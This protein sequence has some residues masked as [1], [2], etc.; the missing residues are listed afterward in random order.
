MTNKILTT[1]FILFCTL[2]MAVMLFDN[3]TVTAQTTAT[4][5]TG[6]SSSSSRGPVQIAGGS[7]TVITTAFNQVYTATEL[8]A[9]GI[10][11]GSTITELQWDIN[12]TNI[13]Q[14]AGDASFKIYIRNSSATSATADTWGNTISG[15]TLVLDRT[16]NTTDNFPGAEGY[17]A[18]PLTTPF[19]YTGD[20][21]EIAVLWDMSGV[22][23]DPAGGVQV[24]DNADGNNGAIKW[25]Y[26]TTTGNLVS[27]KTS[28]STISSG[29]SLTLANEERANMQL[30]YT[31]PTSTSCS[32]TSDPLGEGTS[33]SATRGPFQR[34]SSSSGSVH[35]RAN[36]VYTQAELVTNLGISSGSTISQINW[37]LGSTNTITATGDAT[38]NIY[39]KNSSVTEATFNTWTNIID[40]AT[41]VGTYTFNTSNNFSGIEGFMDFPLSTDFVYT[42]GT[43]EVAVEWDC[44]GLTSTTGDANEL[45]SGNG[46]LNWHWEET[47]HTSLVYRAGSSSAPSDLTGGDLKAERVNT[48]FVYSCDVSDP[49]CDSDALGAGTSSSATRGP[50]QRSSSSSGS[51]HSRANMVY[52]QAEILNTLGISNG[53][54]ISQ[55][56]WDLG[57]TNIITATGDATLNIY[58]KNSTVSEAT[59]DT[60][61]NI[62]DGATLVGTYT[63]NTSNNFPGAKGFMDFP[64][65]TDFVYTGGT[66]EVAVEWDCSGLT[67]TT[68]DAN[69]LFSGNGSLNWFW[70]ETEHTSLIYRTGSS[71]APSDLTG[72][73]LKAERVNTQFVYS[74]GD[75]S[76]FDCNGTSLVA[77]T[78]EDTYTL[79]TSVLAP[80]ADPIETPDCGHTEFD[81]H[82]TQ[83]YDADLEKDVFV[84]H[85]HVDEDDDRCINFDRQ[86]NE[87]K[88]YSESPD[89][90]LGTLGE[91]VQYKWKFK[92]DAGFQSSA[93]FTHIHQLKSVG[94]SNNEDDM[95]QITFTTRKGVDGNPDQ[96]E[97]RYAEDLTQ[98]TWAQTDLTP[99]KG[100]WVEAVE[101]VTYGDYGNG[102]YSLEIKKVSDGSVLFTHTENNTRMWKT[103]ATFIRPKWGIYRSLEQEADLRDEEVLFAD[104]CIEE[105]STVSACDAPPTGLNAT[106]I[107]GTSADLS[108]GAVVGASTYTWK[109]VAAGDGSGGTAIDS[110][111][112]SNTTVST[113]V[114]S[115]STSYDLH[116]E[117]DCSSDGTTGYSTAYNF[118]TASTKITT[119]AIGTGTSS[120]SSRG[121]IHQ[122]GTGASTRYSRYFHVFTQEELFAAGL[123][124]HGSITDLQW[125]LNS[126]DIITGAGDAPFKIYIKNSSATQATEDTWTNL[127]DG[128]T[129]VLDKTFNEANNFPG[130][131]GWMPFT[132]DT[133]FFYTGGSL[134]V[135]VEWDW[136]SVAFTNDGAIKWYYSTFEED[137]MVRALGSTGHSTNLTKSSTSKQR[138]NM[139]ICYEPPSCAAP[140]GLS[141]TNRTINSADLGWDEVDGA[142]SYTWKV[143]EAG[144]GVDATAV[145]TGTTASTSAS[146]ADLSCGT[147]YDLYVQADC[148][149]GDESAFSLPYS[150]ATLPSAAENTITI[151]TGTSSSSSRGPIQQGGG[152]SSTRYSRF[153]QV[154]T[155]AELLDAGLTPNSLITEL[156]WDLNSTDII[157]GSGD[158]PFKV[159]I[160]NSM[161]TEATPIAWE[162]LI[163]GLTPVVDKVF[164]TT[165]NFPGVKGWMPFSF[166]EPFMYTGGALEIAVEWDYGSISEPAFTGSD[167]SNP[168]GGS[169]KWRYSTF[170]HD[171][172]VRSLGSG[173]Y[174]TSNLSYSTSSTLPTERANIQIISIPVS[175]TSIVGDLE[176]CASDSY[177]TL[178]AGTG[179]EYM[180]SNSAVS[181]TIEA[182]EGTYAVTVTDADGCTATGSASVTENANPMPSVSGD[183]GHCNGESTT[184][185]AGTW[186]SYFWSNNA[187]TQTITATVGDYTVTVTNSNDCTGIGEVS[188]TEYAAPIPTI[189]GQ[190]T[191]CIG[192]N[193]ILNAGDW[194]S[195]LWSNNAITQT[196][197]ASMS[198]TYAVTV[199][200]SN[201][202]TGA[203]TYTNTLENICSA[204]AGV[205]TS[206]ADEICAGGDIEASTTGLP[207]GNYLQYFFVYEQD[208]LGNTTLL[209][210]AL[211][212]VVAGES[213]VDFSGLDAGDYLVCSYSEAQD[214]IPNPS[215]IT[216]ELDDIYDTATIQG[217]CFDIECSTVNIPE[218]FEPSLAGTGQVSENNSTGNNVYTVEICGGTAPYDIDFVSS[219]GFGSVQELP[220]ENA[221]CTN[222]QIVYGD[223]TDWTLTVTDANDCNSESSVFTNE[224]LESTPLLQIVESTVTPETC[225]GDK[226]GSITIEVE[227]GDDSCDEYTYAWSS[228]NGFS[229]TIDGGTTGNTISDLAAGFYDVTVTDCAGTTTVAD[230][231]VSRTNGGSGG[232]GRG[233]SGGCKT[234]GNGNVNQD[235]MVYPN[236]FGEQTLI[237]FSLP[238][239][240]KVWLSVYSVDGQKVAELLQGETIE[241][242]S[243]QR[244][245]FEV[246]SLQSGVY[247][248]ELQTESGLRQ[249]QQLVV[250]K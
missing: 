102:V 41:L 65:S 32:I 16:F 56:N 64:L 51:V 246:G 140:V 79:I 144:A 69:E 76:G 123:V 141:A 153:N 68:G 132:F 168:N 13:I 231:Y 17:M 250:L 95:P 1:K 177:T 151:G 180:W 114:L 157:A 206:N 237:E 189:T 72:G 218:A 15:S 199:T 179:T 92:L 217:G 91:E 174:P 201:G 47:G 184:L 70:E 81:D 221:G 127:T 128:A 77:D 226:D 171:A 96:L 138:A 84:F 235:L 10:T 152:T 52:T 156:Q 39:M 204:E 61:V 223:A 227:G 238:E 24:F 133:P 90:L 20:A 37:D 165:N 248:L 240:S 78:N 188:V 167:S 203:A 29:S 169:I 161:A 242:G 209:D 111:T 21:I 118:M 26:S 75:S 225:A 166:N 220:S 172:V 159:Y 53:S 71:S 104:F 233:R 232:R 216:T 97:L 150:F 55:I 154:F 73:D 194:V 80:G 149:E 66:L 178:D 245:T 11:D 103:N 88:T 190:L 82:I 143:V 163:A 28:S 175:V 58:M 25:R 122:A 130:V 129:L 239:T 249:Y 113:T 125:N 230:I 222:Y 176:Y 183:L 134:E 182:S 135:A 228:T 139:Q 89:N 192:G 119:D 67:S 85:L 7:S 27:R 219:G 60:W 3:N 12:S 200:D 212:N 34:S 142:D 105:L 193:A 57:S 185:D 210:N 50:F 215:P 54:T 6:T 18:F 207:I 112:T 236:P 213:T 49:V 202:C 234:A 164:N 38:L 31:L 109:V 214:C 86:R 33:S 131:K 30:I 198:S 110:G 108:W 83:E 117:A 244:N 147:E 124:A 74:C 5:G 197:T 35:S 173:A 187:T 116:V 23:A 22:A 44:S 229:S 101:T 42:G 94:A 137:V 208:N 241:G 243:L 191:S 87:I 2:F 181:Q 148:G 126:T 196:I 8:A 93:R 4:F 43:L 40:G 48:Q 100:V 19:D 115:S 160:K 146:T 120:S 170:E 205:L 14:G 106:N 62:I 145:S 186:T 45:F 211:G 121:P 9:I 158:A 63:F 107:T 195:Y 155:Q 99:F 36:L 162:D 59:E 136:D 98:I 46:S 247:I 224:G